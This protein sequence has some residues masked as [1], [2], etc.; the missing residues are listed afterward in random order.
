MVNQVARKV[1]RLTFRPA[2]FK[3]RMNHDDSSSR[4][5]IRLQVGSVQ[6]ISLKSG[7]STLLSNRLSDVDS[8]PW[9]HFHLG[10]G[11]H[12]TSS[13]SLVLKDKMLEACNS[14]FAAR[15][16]CPRQETDGCISL[17]EV[18]LRIL[19]QPDSKDE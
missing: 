15:T 1:K 10:R 16:A 3:A 4:Q 11:R 8:V 2:E 17:V 6:G 14:Q 7:C 12:L 5:Q 19:L 13:N 18:H 9:H